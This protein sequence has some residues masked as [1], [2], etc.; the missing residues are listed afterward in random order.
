MGRAK[1]NAQKVF[2]QTHVALYR[3]SRGRLGG[4]FRKSPVLLLTTIGR[5]SRKKRTTPV[6][7][8]E[9]GENM[10][11]VASNAGKDRDPFWWMNLKDDPSAIVQLRGRTVEVRAAQATPE[12]KSRYWPSLVKMYPTY[13]DYQK[14]TEREIPVVILRPLRSKC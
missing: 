9:D 6:L 5:K 1:L 13:D 14:K 12:E 2:A 8:I 11:L 7:Y 10:V 3:M 4:R